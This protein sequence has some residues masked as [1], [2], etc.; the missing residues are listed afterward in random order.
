M[1]WNAFLAL[2]LACVFATDSLYAREPRKFSQIHW[3]GFVFFW[4]YLDN[5]AMLDQAF[6]RIAET[7]ARHL[8]IPLFGCQ[9]D[10]TSSDVGSC[11]IYKESIPLKQI[12]RARANGFS[13]T[14]L[15][16][17]LSLS[18]DWRGDFDPT[19]YKKW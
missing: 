5:T 19:D 3:D 16:I 10:K 7:G 4:P 15:P 13:V 1:R 14:V 8:T 9:T 12:E 6:G 18:D 17:V 2:A 11:E